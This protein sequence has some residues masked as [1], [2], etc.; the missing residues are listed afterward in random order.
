MRPERQHRCR[1]SQSTNGLDQKTS[2]ASRVGA[3]YWR[4]PCGARRPRSSSASRHLA[5]SATCARLRSAQ[6]VALPSRARCPLLFLL[7]ACWWLSWKPEI[8]DLRTRNR[9]AS[10]ASAPGDRGTRRY[11][12]RLVG[13][14]L[15]E[16]GI[17]EHPPRSLAAMPNADVTQRTGSDV[18]VKVFDRAVEPGS[19]LGSSLEPVGGR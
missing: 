5:I 2:S 8:D 4:C 3:T 19:S 6:Y 15:V 1:R 13:D 12:S 10:R 18:A 11:L 16:I 9:S 14:E 17:S 7:P